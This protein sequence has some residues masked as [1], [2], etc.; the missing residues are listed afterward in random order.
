[1]ENR[2]DYII[3]LQEIYDTERCAR[4]SSNLQIKK[5]SIMNELEMYSSFIQE[6]FSK[7]CEADNIKKLFSMIESLD[8]ETV[9]E[10]C[11]KFIDLDV[12]DNYYTEYEEG[13]MTFIQDALQAVISKNEAELASYMV[14]ID[15]ALLNDS[16]FIHSIIG[17]E[18]N[19]SINTSVTNGMSILEKLIDFMVKIGYF[20]GRI[21]ELNLI[22]VSD[23]DVNTS[24]Q[25]K[26]FN[27]YY[28]SLSEYCFTI[29][30]SII[31]SYQCIINTMLM[32][33]K[34]DNLI[35]YKLL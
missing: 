2:K 20:K 17:G 14:Q 18:N 5:D 15:K 4:K 25:T 21:S 1:M 31:E 10:R 8:V 24:L 35:K 33:R 32:G 3:K 6:F 22:V 30:R 27:L 23:D 29:I 7:S 26:C 19:K 16:N 28:N 9:D 34:S 12:A 11:I 13:M